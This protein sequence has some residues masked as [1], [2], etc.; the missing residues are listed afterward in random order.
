MTFINKNAVKKAPNI[1]K[2]APLQPVKNIAERVNIK[3]A[4]AK[5]KVFLCLPRNAQKA[6]VVTLESPITKYPARRF[7]LYGFK[8]P[9]TL[10]KRCSESVYDVSCQVA[11]ASRGCKDCKIA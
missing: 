4:I 6:T 7:G 3:E 1:P 2:Y 11:I 8:V 9:Y 5:V 10:D